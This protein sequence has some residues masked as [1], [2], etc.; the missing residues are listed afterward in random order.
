ML[1]ETEVD[2]GRVVTTVITM[3]GGENDRDGDTVT[4]IIV[5]TGGGGGAVTRRVWGVSAEVSPTPHV[6]AVT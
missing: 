5:V 2:R 4:V 6:N 3:T 1:R